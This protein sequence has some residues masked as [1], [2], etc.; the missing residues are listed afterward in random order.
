MMITMKRDIWGEQGYMDIMKQLI[1]LYLKLPRRPMK[2]KGKINIACIGDSLTRGAGVRGKKKLTWEYY[3][4]QM[5]GK[6][7]HVMNC[8]ISGC[9]LMKEGDCPYTESSLYPYTKD[10]R[11]DIYLVMLGSND[12]KPQNW[13]QEK[14]E[15]QLKGFLE[16]YM[17]LENHPSVIVM[18]PVECYPQKDTGE[19][20]FKIS[21]QIIDDV[22][23]GIIRKT[24]EDLGIE[25]ID[26]LEPS[27]DHEEW[28]ADGVHPDAEGNYHIAEIIASHLKKE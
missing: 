25:V 17:S 14:Y 20:A 27:K 13:D 8:G 1:A 24:A 16:G 2:K 22:L 12:S 10:L 9:T 4:D 6:D 7:H 19:V 26:L 5:L 3:L 23:P 28:Y 11:A 21:K 18:I 15:I